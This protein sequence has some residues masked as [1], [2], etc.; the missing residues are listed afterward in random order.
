M[1]AKFVLFASHL[2]GSAALLALGYYWLGLDESDAKHLAWSA[3]VVILLIISATLLHGVTLA[4]FSGLSLSES[5]RKAIRNLLPLLALTLLGLGIYGGLAWISGGFYKAAYAVSS[6]AALATHKAISPS[7][8][9]KGLKGLLCVLQW[10]VVPAILLP[11]ASA[12]AVDGWHGWK[13]RFWPHGKRWFIGWRWPRFF[14]ALS[15]FP[16]SSSFGCPRSKHSAVRW[17]AWSCAGA[18]AICFL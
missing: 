6:S 2:L 10:M 14:S 16:L 9:E 7:I 18:S 1:R 17:L 5:V 3:L 13:T 11:L 12:I 8:S 15:G 4:H